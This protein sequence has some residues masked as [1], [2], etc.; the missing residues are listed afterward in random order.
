MITIICNL[1]EVPIL[2]SKKKV[3]QCFCYWTN[4]RTMLIV[5]FGDLPQ[6]HPIMCFLEWVLLFSP[7]CHEKRK[8]KRKKSYVAFTLASNQQKQIILIFS[9]AT[10]FFSF[11]SPLNH[12]FDTIIK[13]LNLIKMAHLKGYYELFW[14][15]GQRLRTKILLNPK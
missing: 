13:F 12:Y 3:F 1:T 6:Y 5:I 4:L 9:F 2:I 15:M 7:F 10:S 8:R 14:N 11:Y